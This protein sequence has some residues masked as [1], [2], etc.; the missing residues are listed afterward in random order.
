MT[1]RGFREGERKPLMKAGKDIIMVNET[2][3]ILILDSRYEQ[4]RDT[5]VSI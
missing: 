1:A 3:E 2:S 4:A 5:E